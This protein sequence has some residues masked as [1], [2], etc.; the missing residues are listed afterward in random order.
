MVLST[1]LL[2]FRGKYPLYVNDD[3]LNIVVADIVSIAT[4]FTQGNHEVN[5]ITKDMQGL[6]DI[7][8]E[9]WTDAEQ[10]YILF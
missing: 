10:E 2:P 7:C 9:F 1:I 3:E 8:T 5:A 6:H 4:S